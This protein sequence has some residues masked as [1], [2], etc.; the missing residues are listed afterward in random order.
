H[1]VAAVAGG[2]L[3]PLDGMAGCAG[4]TVFVKGAI[5][6]R[7]GCQA[8]REHDNRIVAAIAVAGELNAFGADE[9]VDAG[10]VERSAEGVGVQGLAPLAVGFVVAVRA[11]FGFRESAR[12]NKVVALNGG[13]ARKRQVVFAE[14]KIVGLSYLI[15]VI[16]AL[17]VFTGLCTGGERSG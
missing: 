4:Q 10:A 2:G 12:L 15:S 14:K 6:V 7:V 5:D 1:H 17:G 16:L 11:V 13:I 3:Q 9:D 8:A